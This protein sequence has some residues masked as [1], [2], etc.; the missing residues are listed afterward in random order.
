MQQKRITNSR[1]A[2]AV[3][4]D[5]NVTKEQMRMVTEY[6]KTLESQNEK[7]KE[8]LSLEKQIKNVKKDSLTES[9]EQLKKQQDIIEN[10]GAQR[11]ALLFQMDEE[12]K[13]GRI[14]N[15]EYERGMELV[16]EF[17]AIEKSHLETRNKLLSTYGAE[18]R[19]QAEIIINEHKR[20][21][22]LEESEVFV[23]NKIKELEEENKLLSENSEKY[24]ENAKAITD[25]QNQLTILNQAQKT[26]AINNFFSENPDYFSKSARNI[27]G[28]GFLGSTGGLID[29]IVKYRS[30]K[31]QS[32]VENKEN[33]FVKFTKDF[34]KEFG[35]ASKNIEDIE[36]INKEDLKEKKEDREKGGAEKTL[37][38]VFDVFGG[39][40]EGS[41]DAEDVGNLDVGNIKGS[42]KSN[43]VGVLVDQFGGIIRDMAD[44]IDPYINAG[45]SFVASNKGVLNA[46]LYGFSGP[47]ARENTNDFYTRFVRNANDKLTGSTI[48]KFESYLSNITE[49]AKQGIGSGVE[50]AALLSTVADKTIPHFRA[51]SAYLRRL[52]L[53]GEQGAT[54]RFFGLESI[55]QKTLNSQFGESSYLNQLFESVNANLQDAIS[56]LSD[57]LG[58]DNQYKF[59]TSTQTWLASLYEQGV[60]SNTVTRISNVINALGSGNIS[61]VS[62]DA[63]MQKLMLL[64]MD[65]AGI[66]YATLLQK[67]F[68]NIDVNNLLYNMVDYLQDIS[69]S[70]NSNNVLESAYA[71]MFGLSMTDM[72]AFRNLKKDIQMASVNSVSD[73]EKET[74]ERLNRVDNAAY[75][76]LSEKVD[77]LIENIKFDFSS[78]LAYGTNYAAIKGGKIAFDIG[79][80]IGQIPVIGAAGL[81]VQAAGAAAMAGGMLLPLLGVGLDLIQSVGH[82]I[83]PD[84][85]ITELYKDVG[86]NYFSSSNSMSF[87][88]SSSD[89]EAINNFKTISDK[90]SLRFSGDEYQITQEKIDEE[91]D[92]EDPMLTILK[93]LEKT[94]MGN[95]EDKYAIAV[96]LQG[97]SDEV[98]KSFASIFADEE[99]MT[100]IFG[101]KEDDKR[102]NNLFKYAPDD[103]KTSG[104]KS[105]NSK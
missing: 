19:A 31:K 75:T 78:K 84:N 37:G 92:K 90:S 43:A 53:L 10:I 76:A 28:Y 88:S 40:G 80:A 30:S 55:I 85:T 83:G 29:G 22:E 104:E 6:L 56:N 71:N 52:V 18:Q 16:Y 32:G 74:V 87:G 12:L 93:E 57:K 49:L 1:D 105:P 101:D 65:K 91:L 13:I 86:G 61:A 89:M 51:D 62:S 50:V 23:K 27:F 2:E 59:L 48:I 38:D 96:S 17:D 21:K 100:D 24:K 70:T 64:A 25:A 72:Y 14:T 45:A 33:D 99:S 102:R 97:M 46:S 39:G 44:A 79:S 82:G 54:Q 95:N 42:L 103:E 8:Q 94:F 47:G 77:T 73:I 58:S 60:D 26:G 4:K 34:K 7:L 81:P 5:N 11:D 20:K 98:L 3:L 15:E 35:K 68:T 69:T 67:G 63:G 66:D 9:S 36:N 41:P